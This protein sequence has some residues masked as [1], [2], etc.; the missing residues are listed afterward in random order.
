MFP[1][2]AL[3]PTPPCTQHAHPLFGVVLGVAAA[4]K[5]LVIALQ[6]AGSQICSKHLRHCLRRRGGRPLLSQRQ[7]NLVEA[8]AALKVL[9]A[10]RADAH[11][12]MC[13]VKDGGGRRRCV[14]FPTGQLPRTALELVKQVP[15]IGV[16]RALRQEER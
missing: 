4:A 15:D 5:I 1:R 13:A 8:L 14:I 2:R 12:D 16:W 11:R 10:A 6:W 9:L 3:I 7:R